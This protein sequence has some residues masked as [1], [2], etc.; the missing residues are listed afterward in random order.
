MQQALDSPGAEVAAG[1]KS[2]RKRKLTTKAQAAGAANATMTDVKAAKADVKAAKADGNAQ[3][4]KAAKAAKASQASTSVANKTQSRLSPALVVGSFCL[5]TCTIGPAVCMCMETCPPAVEAVKDAVCRNVISRAEAADVAGVDAAY[6]GA[7]LQGNEEGKYART[8]EKLAAGLLNAARPF[9]ERLCKMELQDC[10]DA[11]S[12]MPA[13]IPRLNLAQG[14]IAWLQTTKVEKDY[15]PFRPTSTGGNDL[16]KKGGHVEGKGAG[17]AYT[18]RGVAVVQSCDE[19]TS[20]CAIVLADKFLARNGGGLSGGSLY[21]QGYVGVFPDVPRDL[22]SIPL[23]QLRRGDRAV[24]PAYDESDDDV[25][26]LPPWNVWVDCVVKSPVD[27]ATNRMVITVDRDAGLTDAE[28]SVFRN[29]VIPRSMYASLRGIDLFKGMRA[30]VEV[31][32]GAPPFCTLKRPNFDESVVK[33]GDVVVIPYSD[34]KLCTKLEAVKLVAIG[35]YFYVDEECH[36]APERISEIEE[37]GVSSDAFP[38]FKRP[39]VWAK[40]RVQCD[41]GRSY[42]DI[43]AW[44]IHP[45]QG[46]TMPWGFKA[47]AHSHTGGR[48]TDGIQRVI[49]GDYGW[50]REDDPLIPVD[51]APSALRERTGCGS[52]VRDGADGH[53]RRLQIQGQVQPCDRYAT[54]EQLLRIDVKLVHTRLPDW[55][56]GDQASFADPYRSS[57]VVAFA[58]ATISAE[59]N[60]MVRVR[61]NGWFWPSC[62]MLTHNH[63]GVPEVIDNYCELVQCDFDNYSPVDVASLCQFVYHLMP[64]LYGGSCACKKRGDGVAYCKPEEFPTPATIYAS[65]RASVFAH[66]ALLSISLVLNLC[67]DASVTEAI[68]ASPQ[69]D[70]IPILSLVGADDRGTKTL[71]LR[72]GRPGRPGATSDN[73]RQYCESVAIVAIKLSTDEQFGAPIWEDERPFGFVPERTHF[74]RLGQTLCTSWLGDSANGLADDPHNGQQTSSRS[75]ISVLTGTALDGSD[76]LAKLVTQKPSTL[77]SVGDDNLVNLPVTFRSGGIAGFAEADIERFA[78]QLRKF[79]EMKA[80][81]DEVVLFDEIWKTIGWL[82]ENNP[83]T[84][85]SAADALARRR[86]VPHS[87]NLGGAPLPAWLEEPDDENWRAP[88]KKAPVEVTLEPWKLQAI[89]NAVRDVDREKLRKLGEAASQK[90]A[91]AKASRDIWG[92]IEYLISIRLLPEGWQRGDAIPPTPSPI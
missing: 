81:T 41:D 14:D 38:R 68:G 25:S 58:T 69:A 53:G 1:A 17:G 55:I 48:T 3:K 54:L 49:R 22:L 87:V 19:R 73:D 4:K 66:V 46:D 56:V 88:F 57:G 82:V 59:S 28:F 24:C 80:N 83:L 60:A 70:C 45:T 74:A 86:S 5:V 21:G 76:A 34:G 35:Y 43:D 72:D 39:P 11:A 37:G 71:F 7:F 31:D 36:G 47:T 26:T 32:D 50:Q 40:W 6:I 63:A 64:S 61:R 65:T 77:G 27:P 15:G 44:R 62:V 91:A 89:A 8:A 30:A 92:L 67:D 2:A 29:H 90:S 84:F 42:D 33:D 75:G 20:R 78:W 10:S 9:M 52:L 51:D 23:P 12:D 85:A 79:F 13:S 16:R 18:V